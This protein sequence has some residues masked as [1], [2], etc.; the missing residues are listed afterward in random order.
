MKWRIPAVLFI[1]CLLALL[2]SI[3]LLWQA[4]DSFSWMIGFSA[5]LLAGFGAVASLVWL[6]VA[7]AQAKPTMRKPNP[8]APFNA[9]QHNPSPLGDSLT[10]KPPFNER[11]EELRQEARTYEEHVKA[12]RENGAQGWRRLKL[13]G[14]D[15]P[16]LGPTNTRWAGFRSIDTNKKP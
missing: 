1:I 10:H 7:L 8:P 16:K 14:D 5:I 2:L 4:H 13:P 15:Q 12:S 11:W 9:Y 3:G 6:L